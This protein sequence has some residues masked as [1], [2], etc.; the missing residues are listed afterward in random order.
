MTVTSP[1]P[2]ELLTLPLGDNDAGAATVRDYLIELLSTLWRK[3]GSFSGKQPFGNSGWVEQIYRPMV[4]AGWVRGAFDEDDDL[5]D[6]DVRA[7]DALIE[8]AIRSLGE[9]P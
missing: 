9:W 3:E 5:I 4:R 1:S 2:A 8:A 7:A 6:C